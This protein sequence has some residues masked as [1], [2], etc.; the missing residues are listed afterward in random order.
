MNTNKSTA[1]VRLDRVA[2]LHAEERRPLCGLELPI[3]V[4]S[5]FLFL[6]GIR[7][8]WR[9][10]LQ[11][12]ATP[13]GLSL[14]YS[15]TKQITREHLFHWPLA[16]KSPTYLHGYSLRKGI[17]VERNKE[18]W[19]LGYRSSS[20]FWGFSSSY[21]KVMNPFALALSRVTAKSPS[22]HGV[23]IKACK[24]GW[25]KFPGQALAFLRNRL[26]ALELDLSL[27]R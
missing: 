12:G 27:L 13:L 18:Q 24:T 22:W 7:S 26:K 2:F 14:L 9:D 10:Y 25:R 23:H 11:I 6:L 20:V 5:F 21:I 4:Q 15:C 1:S 19:K 8:T 17:T 3:E 16:I